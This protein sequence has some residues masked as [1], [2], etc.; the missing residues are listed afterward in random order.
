M[1][2]GL[3]HG[4]KNRNFTQNALLWHFWEPISGFLAITPNWLVLEFWK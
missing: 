3:S 2:V 4:V 1:L